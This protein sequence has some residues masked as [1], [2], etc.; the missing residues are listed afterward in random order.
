MDI[1]AKLGRLNKAIPI[2]RQVVRMKVYLPR[3]TRSIRNLKSQ[4]KII[5]PIDIRGEDPRARHTRLARSIKHIKAQ[6]KRDKLPT[7]ISHIQK[8]LTQN[9]EIEGK[10]RYQLLLRALKGGGV[11]LA[12]LSICGRGTREIRY[13]QLLRYF[14]DPKE[15]H[16]V[17]SK[18]LGAVIGP[19]MQRAGYKIRSV[20]WSQASVEAEFNL[21]KVRVKGREY[22]CT[23]DLFIQVQEYVIMVENKINSPETGVVSSGEIS[24]LKRYS[25][26][27]T[28]NFPQ[29]SS[30][31]L[32]KIFLTPDGRAPKEDLDWTPTS[33]QQLIG[34]V[35]E[36]LNDDGISRVGRHN[37]SCFLWDLITGPLA[38]D[39]IKRKQLSMLITEAII[40][41]RK[42]LRLKRWCAENI[43]NIE[44]ILMIVEACYG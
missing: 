18:V 15:P 17:N 31:N 25:T 4:G 13:T 43:E 16:G 2:I 27:L 39:Q 22:G 19:D 20:N 42:H 5:S 11:P 3:A 28:A 14:L 8:K 34:R 35:V 30:K 40:D 6:N 9:F 32:L 38:L 41:T 36:I 29:L 33:Y 10:T 23:V 37:L 26:A 44:H 1:Q 21:G 24:Q 7:I 12:S